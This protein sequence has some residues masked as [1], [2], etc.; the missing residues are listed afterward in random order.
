[1][2]C[3]LCQKSLN[4]GEASWTK[5]GDNFICRDCSMDS[6]EFFV[7]INLGGFM[8]LWLE[9]LKDKYFKT[10]RKKRNC[11][12][13]LKVRKVILK[14]YKFTCQNCRSKENLTIDHII[15]VSKG[16]SDNL[17]NLTILCKSCNSK[18]GAKI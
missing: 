8:L 2:K 16:G 11:Y 12:L 7:K 15:P 17:N 1:M 14:K 9:H 10:F 18:K 5:F 4:N 6:A 13:P 3:I